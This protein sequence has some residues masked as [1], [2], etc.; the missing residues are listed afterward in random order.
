M[1]V[2]DYNPLDGDVST[3]VENTYCIF[4]NIVEGKFYIYSYII[5]L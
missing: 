3:A 2:E 5:C 1:S 4:L